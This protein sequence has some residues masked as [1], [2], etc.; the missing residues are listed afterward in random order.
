VQDVSGRVRPSDGGYM[1]EIMDFLKNQIAQPNAGS[2]AIRKLMMI[3]LWLLC[4]ALVQPAVAAEG[5]RIAT[6]QTDATPPIGYDM[7]YSVVKT[8]R[9]PLLAKGVVILGAGKPIVMMAVDWVT[10]DG[11]ARDEWHA[12]LAQAAGT[13]PDRVTVHHLHQHDAPRGDLFNFDERARLGLPEAVAAGVPDKRTWVRSVM[14]NSAAALTRSLRQARPVT[15]VGTGKANAERLGANRRIMGANG[16]VAMHRQS[17][18]TNV[19]P[20]E[21]AARIKVDADADGHRLSIYHP[22]EAQAAPEGLMDPAVRVIS[23]WNGNRALAALTYYASHPQVAFGKGIPTTDFPGTAREARQKE[24][25]VFQVYFTGAGGNITLGKYN[26]GSDRARQEFA[27]RLQDAMGRAWTATTRS[28]LTPADVE[29]RTTDISLPAKYGA[30]KDE[31]RAVAADTTRPRNERIA[32]IGKYTRAQELEEGTTLAVLRL[33]KAYS[34]HIPGESFVEY[35]LG[36][37]A[38]RPNDFVAM[39]AYAEGLGYIGHEKAYGEGGYE[40]TVSQTTLAAEKVMMDGVRKLL[41]Q[42]P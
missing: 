39:A 9:E 42:Q 1:G 36:A 38:I 23:F 8:I 19:Y 41:E 4:A 11:K 18:F 24:T 7:G 33:G 27:G 30:F 15:H 5:L 34:V 22:E 2:F 13:T 28:A 14:E 20:A 40:I 31:A 10:I 16:R 3:G 12:L 25:G 37:Q 35:Q 29:W 26:D 21:V 17:T 32:A 6:F